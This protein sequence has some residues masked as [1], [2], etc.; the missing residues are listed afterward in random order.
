MTNLEILLILYFD[1][2][3]IQPRVPEPTVVWLRHEQNTVTEM[4]R[5]SGSICSTHPDTY[6]TGQ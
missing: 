4:L 2:F 3:G 1:K 6:N 5:I